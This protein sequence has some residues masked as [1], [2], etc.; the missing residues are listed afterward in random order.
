MAL[1]IYVFAE[2]AAAQE[3]LNAVATFLSLKDYSTAIAIAATVAVILAAIRFIMTHDLRAMF[4]WLFAYLIITGVMLIPVKGDVQIIDASNPMADYSV[5]HLPLGIVIPGTMITSVTYA[6][7]QDFDEIYSVPGELDFSQ[8]GM[9]FGSRLFRA[10]LQANVTDSQ[11]QE[12]IRNFFE[13]CIE[14]D[15]A[16]GEYKMSDITQNPDLLASLQGN[17]SISLPMSQLRGVYNN[18]GQF[19]TCS[20]AVGNLAQ[21]VSQAALG[22]ESNISSIL[23]IPAD[24]VEGNINDVYAYYFNN[25]AVANQNILQQNIL[26]NAFRDAANAVATS[27]NA[28][29]GAI[30]YAYTNTE[31]NN[32]ITGLSMA[33][34]AAD[35]IPMMHTIFTLMLMG[36]FPIIMLL[37]IQPTLFMQVMKNYLYA[38]IYLA[39]WPFLFDFLNFLMNYF[40]SQNTVG[41]IMGGAAGYVGATLSTANALFNLNTQAAAYCGYLM[42]AVPFL[43]PLLVKG[44]SSGISMLGNHFAGSMQS[45]ASSYAAQVQAG[46]F[47][48]GTTSF[49]NQS[50]NNVSAN[51]WDTNSLMASGSSTLQTPFGGMMTQ[52]ASGNMVYNTSGAQ[53][54]LPVSLDM[55]KSISNAISSNIGQTTQAITDTSTALQKSSSLAANQMVQLGNTASAMSTTGVGVSMTSSNELSQSYNQALDIAEQYKSDHNLAV[56]NVEMLQSMVKG[57]L[58]GQL[59]TPGAAKGASPLSGS[60]NLE[61]SG[62]SISE[63]GVTST[64]NAYNDLATNQRQGIDNFIRM[65]KQYAA[66]EHTDLTNSQG[67]QLTKDLQSTLSNID[68][69]SSTLSASMQKLQSYHQEQQTVSSSQFSANETPIY[70]SMFADYMTKEHPEAAETLLNNPNLSENQREYLQTYVNAFAHQVVNSGALVGGIAANDST[71]QNYATASGAIRQE[72]SNMANSFDNQSQAISSG[73]KAGAIPNAGTLTQEVSKSFDSAGNQIDGAGNNLSNVAGSLGNDVN[74]RFAVGDAISKEG[75]V[76]GA[77]KATAHDLNPENFGHG[78]KTIEN[79]MVNDSILNTESHISQASTQGQGQKK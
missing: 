43:P 64:S 12:F 5:A 22:Q 59:S 70:N 30:N 73:F 63:H 36:F 2:G 28:T 48:M 42:M 16:L 27:D 76:V 4:L 6:L 24:N 32:S 23:N 17:G 41:F 11:D 29:A 45:S 78:V 54:I 44:M 7:V 1:P 31:E 50:F 66:T 67:M 47:T 52:T 14:Q 71:P 10:S 74:N 25:E 57:S 49:G 75:A 65:S 35:L 15:V 46:D 38:Y 9:M 33:N 19:E 62:S 8:T 79:S 39:S 26:V 3:V 20:A 34:M 13:N 21:I 72:A 58:Q 68:Q 55:Q 60:A 61:L 69:E 77:I 51:K 37:A 40:I 18:A 53:D 56:S